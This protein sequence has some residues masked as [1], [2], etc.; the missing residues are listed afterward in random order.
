VGTQYVGALTTKATAKRWAAILDAFGTQATKDAA[1]RLKI[2][3]RAIAAR[4]TV[5]QRYRSLV[6]QCMEK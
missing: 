6:T 3:W 5:S 1:L 2:N 4:P